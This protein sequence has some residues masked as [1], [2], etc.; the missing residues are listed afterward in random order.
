[1]KIRKLALLLTL[2]LTTACCLY[3]FGITVAAA[4]EGQVVFSLDFEGDSALSGWTQSSGTVTIDNGAL[5]VEKGR[6]DFMGTGDSAEKIM[7]L[8]RGATYRVSYRAK[9]AAAKAAY[10]TGFDTS[11]IQWR[12]DPSLADGTLR[13]SLNDNHTLFRNPAYNETTDWE[14]V[15][16]TFTLYEMMNYSK[17][18][19]VDSGTISKFYVVS[20]S[21]T[22]WI[23]D[24]VITKIP[25]V[26]V[27][28]DSSQ[29][30]VTV[31][32]QPVTDGQTLLTTGGDFAVTPANG[33]ELASIQVTRAGSTEVLGSYP[34]GGRITFAEDADV[35]VTFRQ[36]TQEPSVTGV[37]EQ[38]IFEAGYSYGQKTYNS[39][40][41]FATINTSGKTMS[42]FGIEFKRETGTEPL[43]LKATNTAITSD[44]RFGIRVFG[45]PLTT[46]SYQARAYAKFS[47]GTSCYEEGWRTVIIQ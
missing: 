29:G 42:E 16:F 3:G 47:D 44:G 7:T 31:D 45:D 41:V 24:I 19:V 4:S 8:E 10:F 1:M 17:T 35:T 21:T 14:T 6:A 15:T 37:A 30:S 26:T 36:Q 28:F 43:I 39:I 12:F 2:V 25:Q 23:D 11:K 13:N 5:K 18:Q 27:H 33:Y 38:M 34:Q 9:T 46:G 22:L 32:G 20:N 40:V